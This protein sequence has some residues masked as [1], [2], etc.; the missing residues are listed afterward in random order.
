MASRILVPLDGSPFAEWALPTAVS[1]AGKT[2]GTVRLVSVVENPPA[3]VRQDASGPEYDRMQE[4]LTSVMNRILLQCPGKIERV[5]RDSFELEERPPRAV[6]GVDEL[7]VH[8]R[9]VSERE[10]ASAPR[11]PLIGRER[12]LAF[13]Q[14]NWRKAVAAIGSAP[15]GPTTSVARA[16]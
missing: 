12:E 1:L 5:V 13:L 8:Y 2:G 9:V 4:Y 10:V 11:G 14:E 3:F 7:I 6:K 15:S 16:V